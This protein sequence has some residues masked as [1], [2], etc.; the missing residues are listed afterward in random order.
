MLLCPVT[1]CDLTRSSYL[2][3]GDNYMLSAGVMKWFWDAYLPDE[4]QR[5]NPK[6]SPLHAASLAGLPPAV[7]VTCEFD[8][9]ADEG[10]AYAEA[11]ANAGVEVHHIRARGH[12]HTSL[13]AVDAMLSGA[14][15]RAEMTAGI[16]RLL[17]TPAMV[18]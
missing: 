15:V 3:C 12:I 4:S 11:M 2:A 9:L 13:T 1:D 10:A 7:V 8:P 14:S 17:T 6:A 16:R 5:R 18:G